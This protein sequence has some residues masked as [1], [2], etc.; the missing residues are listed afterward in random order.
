MFL[1]IYLFSTTEASQL[2]KLPV[3]F[4]HF[5]E[6]KQEGNNFTLLEFLEM[7]YMH[8]NSKDADYD[9]DMQ[10]PFKA[11]G[12]CIS[13]ISTAFVPLTVQFSIVAPMVIP[14]KEKFFSQDQIILTSY[15][16]KIWQPPK[17]C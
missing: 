7:H 15:L 12:D 11:S 3:I 17:S 6:H 9:R 16:S 8:G 10:L 2:L 5:Q 13:S 1:A 4:Q 14:Q